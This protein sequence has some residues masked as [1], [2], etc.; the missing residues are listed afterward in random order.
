L[1]FVTALELTGMAIARRSF[2]HSLA[3]SLT[4]NVGLWLL[5]SHHRVGI[6]LHPQLWLIPLG[7]I[8]L[9]SEYVNSEHLQREQRLALR[10][11]GLLLLYVSSTADLFLNGVGASVVLPLALSVLSVLGV[12]AGLMLR[13]R[14]FLFLGVLFLAVDV[15]SMIWYAA[16]DRT[17]T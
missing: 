14:A 3:A 4:A 16:V 10:Y 6:F 13:V 11:A 9:V 1:W 7:L 12:L 8:V 5:L 17:Q 2:F 15:M